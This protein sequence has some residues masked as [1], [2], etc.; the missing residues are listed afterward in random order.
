MP[1]RV[2]AV[3]GRGVVPADT[4]VLGDLLDSR[5]VQISLIAPLSRDVAPVPDVDGE[6]LK[7]S[8]MHDRRVASMKPA[9]LNRLGRGFGIVVVTL[10][11][12][13]AADDDLADR[14]AIVG[15]LLAALT[16]DDS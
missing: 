10:E 12:H 3:L 5:L 1:D 2:V 8:R 9:V 13:V 15:D 11:D 4:P 16:I 6:S 14:A 7:R